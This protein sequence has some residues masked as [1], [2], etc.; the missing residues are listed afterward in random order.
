MT[1]D[2]PLL[3]LFQVT[4]LSPQR[5]RL[6]LEALARLMEPPRAA[7]LPHDHDNNLTLLIAGGGGRGGAITVVLEDL[8]F[9]VTRSNRTAVSL[10]PVRQLLAHLDDP[11]AASPPS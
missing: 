3:H 1:T 5:V 11:P 2:T 6:A 9:T 8:G 7:L 4:S 10:Q